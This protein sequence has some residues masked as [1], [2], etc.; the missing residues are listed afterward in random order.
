MIDR[1]K[2]PSNLQSR[3]RT[4][5]ADLRVRNDSQ[6][7]PEGRDAWADYDTAKQNTNHH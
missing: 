4:A 3:L 7:V 5:E 1:L 2:L 6:D